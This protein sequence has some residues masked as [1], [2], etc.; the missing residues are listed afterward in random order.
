MSRLRRPFRYDRYIFVTVD[1][2]RW[3]GKVEERDYARLAISLARMRQKRVAHSFVSQKLCGFSAV[4]KPR[5]AAVEV[6]KLRA[7][8]S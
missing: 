2:L 1:L 6:H 3:K 7:T 8:C 5:A 4:S